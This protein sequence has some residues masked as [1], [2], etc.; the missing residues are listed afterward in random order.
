MYQIIERWFDCNN[1]GYIICNIGEPE[2]D[3]EEAKRF[4]SEL[5]FLCGGNRY[6]VVLRK[7][8]AS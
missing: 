8:E 5:N 7:E 3:Y 4:C 2:D 1:N 6:F